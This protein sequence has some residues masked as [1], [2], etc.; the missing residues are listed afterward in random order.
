MLRRDEI[1]AP[2]GF[3]DGTFILAIG[4]SGVV[5]KVEHAS[6]LAEGRANTP[7]ELWEVVGVVESLIGFAPVALI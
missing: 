5:G 1:F 3:G 6:L 7:G 2:S 4:H